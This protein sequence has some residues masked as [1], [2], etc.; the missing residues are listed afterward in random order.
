M[1]SEQL[2]NFSDTKF[3]ERVLCKYHKLLTTFLRESQIDKELRSALSGRI[4]LTTD[5]AAWERGFE[6]NR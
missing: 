3:I 2:S 5:T 1:E 4:V 6:V